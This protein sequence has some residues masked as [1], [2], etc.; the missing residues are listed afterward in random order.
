MVFVEHPG[1]GDV[2]MPQEP[3]V[4]IEQHDGDG[5]VSMSQ[6]EL[7]LDDDG[8]VTMEGGTK[9]SSMSNG[10]SSRPASRRPSNKRKFDAITKL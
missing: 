5:D 4:L 2:S 10:S 1:D 7:V 3:A 8:D 6:E 9:H